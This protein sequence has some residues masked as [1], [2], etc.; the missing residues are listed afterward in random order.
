MYHKF[1]KTFELEFKHN[2]H[3]YWESLEDNKCP[4]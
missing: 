2:Y 1:H 4:D 3:N